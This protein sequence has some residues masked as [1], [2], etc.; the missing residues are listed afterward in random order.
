MAIISQSNFDKLV[1]HTIRIELNDGSTLI[2][3]VSKESKTAFHH[4]LKVDDISD[5][6]NEFLWVYIPED[7]LVLV[8]KKEIVRFTFCFDPLQ[9]GEPKYRDNFAVIDISEE[10]DEV[11]DR[12]QPEEEP[13]LPQ[14]ILKHNRQ[15]EDTE[16]VSGVAMKTEGYFGN[17]SSYYSLDAGDVE[18]FDFEYLEDM[19]EWNLLTYKYLQFIDDDGEE[20]FMP[21]QQLSVIEIERP[22]IMPD[23][24]LDQYVGRKPR[25]QPRKRK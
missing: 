20:N 15:H 24:K 7:R 3:N 13:D 4:L 18:G 25:K 5:Y 9:A 23:Q 22:L 12:Q 17:V 19:E 11:D 2:Y 21:L 16:F 6:E 14:L 10:Q 1:S 8:N